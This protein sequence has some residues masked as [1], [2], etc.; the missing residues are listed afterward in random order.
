[1]DHDAITFR[2]ARPGEGQ[3]VFDLTHR[4]VGGLAAQHYTPEQIAGWMGERTPAFYES[5][6]AN[7]RMVVAL[8]AG[9]VVGFVDADPG[10][11]TRLFVLPDA[12]G[13]GIG[14]RLL[15]RGIEIARAGHSGPIRLEATLNAERFYQRHG[16]VT[17]GHGTFSHGVGGDPI[18][19]VHM[20]LP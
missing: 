11:V 18:P 9:R 3:A 7:G 4:S 6:I 16:F 15:D 19:I 8:R 14:R 5:L 13:L 10:E 20:A 1:M 2:A 12:A 17:V